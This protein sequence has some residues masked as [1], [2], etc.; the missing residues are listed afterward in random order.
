VNNTVPF[1]IVGSPRSGTGM[2]RDSLRS[3]P[4]L[5]LP[6]E[7]HFIPMLYDAYGDPGSSQEAEGL[8][9]RVLAYRHVKSWN[10]DL[11]PRAFS[12][13]RSYRE[14]VS[15][16][17]GEWARTENKSRWG[18]KTP[19]Y[20]RRIPTLVRIFPDAQFIHIIRDGRDA[21]LSWLREGFGPGNL[22]VG[23]RM[24]RANVT[25][26]RGAGHTLRSEQYLEIRYEELTQ[27]PLQVL[28]LVCE[29]LGEEFDEAVL[30]LNRP[31]TGRYPTL[32]AGSDTPDLS[33]DRIVPANSKKWKKQLSAADQVWFESIAGDLLAELGYETEGV[34][35]RIG[36]VEELRWK[37]HQ[38]YHWWSVRLRG[39]NLPE[40]I[41]SH[42]IV[43]KAASHAWLR[44]RTGR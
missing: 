14:V 29:F 43:Q 26:G 5:T 12:E 18:D 9:G 37:L 2:L 4:R 38:G 42:L 1:F 40:L 10:L 22:L 7:S 30:R 27:N 41:R 35:R 16:L 11:N 17:F 34:T 21:V 25:A 28:R 31:P 13:C 24:W 39:R 32:I 36:V 8:A 33:P 19:E 3:H 23:A 20:V 6:R 15:R 44:R